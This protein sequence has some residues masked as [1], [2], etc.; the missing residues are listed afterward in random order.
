MRFD[1]VTGAFIDVFVTAGAGGLDAPEGIAFGP[2][3]NADTIAELYVASRATNQILRYDG[4]TGAF[5]DVFA[6][7]GF[8]E[9]TGIAFG[10][11]ANSDTIPELFVSGFGS[12]N[13]AEIDGA[14]GAVIRER[15][16]L[17]TCRS[18]WPGGD[19]LRGG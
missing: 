4:A 15:S 17:R 3:S 7:G 19:L 12:D 1:G 5:I 9:P 11:D 10:R 18:R 14:T 16:A 6:Y 13:V 8:V 2:D